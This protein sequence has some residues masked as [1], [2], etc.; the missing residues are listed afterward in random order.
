MI[1]GGNGDKVTLDRNYWH[2]LS[3]RAPKIGGSTG[4][5]VVQA[6]NNW[7]AS[8]TGHN[9]D[10]SASGRVLI[11]G[12]RFESST[13]PITTAT[14]TSAVFDVPDSGSTS[15][16]SSPLG[17]VCVI[18]ALSGSGAWPSLKATQVLTELGKYKANLVKPIPYGDV[19]TTVSNNYGIGRI[20]N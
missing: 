1:I 20:G 10:V 19:K 2:D 16:C 6:V 12:N 17:R 15:T 7:F 13:T 3:G 4:L 9:F 8:N 18:N 11:E 5:Q 14:S